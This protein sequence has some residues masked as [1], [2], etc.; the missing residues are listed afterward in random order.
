[1]KSVLRYVGGKSRAVKHILPYLEDADVLYSPFFGGGSIE[2]AFSEKGKVIACDLYEPVAVFWKE[3]IKNPTLVADK[4]QE[5]H[6]LPKDKFYSLQ[7][8]LPNL[9]KPLEMASVFYVLNRASFSGSTNSGGMSPSH[10]R[11]NQASIDRL[12]K[13]SAPNVEMQHKDAFVFLE[14]LTK[15]DPKG[16]VIY[17]DPPYMIKN[18]LYG[19]KGDMHKNF[20]HKKLADI[21]KKLDSLGWRIVLSYNRSEKIE[22]WYSDFHIIP[23]DWKYGMNASKDSNEYLIVNF[24]KNEKEMIE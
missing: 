2:F 18:N 4:V 14:E 13:F 9:E 7:K 3:A 6:P 17:L 8:E 11:F 12:K 16:K 23:V 1:M 10:P 5:Y 22:E 20:N 21:V 19:N 24:I 15:I